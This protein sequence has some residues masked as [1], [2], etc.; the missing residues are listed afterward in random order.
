MQQ[1]LTPALWAAARGQTVCEIGPGDCT[2]T[3]ALLLAG[4][5]RHV[6]LIEKH[7]PLLD[8]NQAEILKQLRAQGI[9]LDLDLLQTGDQV[10]LNPAKATLRRFY[11]EDYNAERHYPF[12]YSLNVLEH[13]EDLEGFFA[14]CFRAT[15]PGGWNVHIIDL[16]GHGEFEAPVPPLDFQ[17]Y[18][19]RLFGW[20]FPPYHRATRRFVGDYRVAAERAGFVIADLR[21]LTAADPEYVRKIWPKLRPA[22]RSRRVE[23]VSVIEFA[24]IAS[25]PAT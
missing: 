11:M 8:R 23:E 25:R 10:S 18:S 15:L 7:P 24:L 1:V 3:A 12:V 2:A 9:A 13:V 22:A 21:T 4:G 17:T 5:A 16:G 14:S 19:D 20:M 6:D